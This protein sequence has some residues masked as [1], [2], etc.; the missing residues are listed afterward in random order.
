[1]DPEVPRMDLILH[2]WTEALNLAAELD[3]PLWADDRASRVVVAGNIGAAPS[4]RMTTDSLI[5]AAVAW[6]ELGEEEG[7]EYLRALRRFNHRCLLLRSEE[8]DF[9]LRRCDGDP[10]G[11]LLCELLDYHRGC[12]VDLGKATEQKSVASVPNAAL[13]FSHYWWRVGRTLAR[14][15]AAGVA[16]GVAG[17]V[18]GRL[19]IS[20]VAPFT[21]RQ[22]GY[23]AALVD[24]FVQAV[25]EDGPGWGPQARTYIVE[26][27]AAGGVPQQAIAEAVAM[28]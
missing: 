22:S 2:P 18:F 10:Q 4:T 15:C 9:R 5:A 19:D 11:A 8:V 28:P 1:M 3:L 27:I 12:A 7:F 16:A 24:H 13:G 25:S 26:A 17:E 14:L 21:E 20:R 23:L 6:G